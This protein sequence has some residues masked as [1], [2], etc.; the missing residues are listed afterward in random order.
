MKLSRE[1]V[2]RL[3]TLCR[4]SLSEEEMERFQE[5]LSHILENFEVMQQVDTSDV[6]P[7][8]YPIPLENVVGE[9]EVAPSLPQSDILANAP[10]QEEGYFRVKAVLEQ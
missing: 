2:L 5:Q 4:L 7:T 8:A 6:P 9:D 1:E 3:A 10:H